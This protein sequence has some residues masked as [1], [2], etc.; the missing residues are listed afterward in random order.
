MLG[1]VKFQ[2]YLSDRE[3]VIGCNLM[4]HFLS[5]CP[6]ETL[7]LSCIGTKHAWKNTKYITE[8]PSCRLIK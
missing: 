7:F 8:L 5:L 2:G 4:V 1:G 6:R 3:M